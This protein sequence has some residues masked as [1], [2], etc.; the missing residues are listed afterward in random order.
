MI[1]GLK[2]VMIAWAVVG[3]LFALGFFFAPERLCSMFGFE[4]V[5]PYVPYFLSIIG[6]AYILSSVFVI[7]AA[8]NPLK[9]IMWVQ[10][11]TA[12]SLLE[13]IATSYFII[14]GNINFSQAGM[15]LIINVIFFVVF[16][17]LYPWR[18][19]PVG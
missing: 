6:I 18:K 4:K 12:W 11:A 15:G 7:I 17:A 16:P 19:A 5:P 10:L 3:I 14:R 1:K 8:R 13:A 2:V 9:H